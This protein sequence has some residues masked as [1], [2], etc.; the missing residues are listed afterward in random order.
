[1][2]SDRAI[3]PLQDSNSLNQET[4][5]H[6]FWWFPLDREAFLQEINFFFCF[7]AFTITKI[8]N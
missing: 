2:I 3:A 4:E 5:A 8:T 6:S 7:V 1:M